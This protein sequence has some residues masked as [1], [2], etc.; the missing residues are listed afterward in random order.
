MYVCM[1]VC[2]FVFFFEK[3]NVTTFDERKKNINK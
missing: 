3:L 2:M 1:Y